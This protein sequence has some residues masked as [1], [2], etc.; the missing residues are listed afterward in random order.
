MNKI[1]VYI[2][3]ICCIFMFIFSYKQFIKILEQEK[4]IYIYQQKNIDNIVWKYITCQ[5]GSDVYR[6][7]ADHV[8]YDLNASQVMVSDRNIQDIDFAFTNCKI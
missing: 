8:Y 4:Q 5:H 6:V 7:K 2:L 3:Y 1:I